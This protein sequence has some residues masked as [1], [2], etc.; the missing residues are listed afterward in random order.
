M[1]DIRKL[2]TNHLLIKN[3]NDKRV[4][5][6]MVKSE[7]MNNVPT[8]IKEIYIG[9]IQKIEEGLRSILQITDK[10][11][12]DNNTIKIPPLRKDTE[13]VYFTI[14]LIIKHILKRLDI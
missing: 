1:I 7:L 13:Y 11:L 5:N 8:E 6:E 14:A 4:L 10:F 3:E 9:F 2:L 12:H